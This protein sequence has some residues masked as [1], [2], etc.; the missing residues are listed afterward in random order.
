MFKTIRTILD[1]REAVADKKEIRFSE[2]DN[3]V[4]IGCY[5]FMDSRTFDTTEALEC[6]GIAFDRDGNVIS[7]PL[8]KFFNVGEKPWLSPESLLERDDIIGVYEKLDGSMIATAWIDEQLHWR[9]KKS[10]TS[11]VVTL[12]KQLLTEPEQSAIEDFATIVADHGCTAIFELTHPDA[13]I[14]VEQDRARLRLLHIRDNETG[15][16]VLTDSAN[17][18]WRLIED[19]GIPV[20]ERMGIDAKEAIASLET[21]TNCEGYVIQFANGDMCKLKCPWY[22]RLHRSI[23]FL[24]ERNIAELALCGELDDVKQSLVEAGVD[25]TAVL[26]VET[27]VKD[28]LV[29]ITEQVDAIYAEGNG[30]D[31]KS[32][33][34]KN[35]DHPLFSLAMSRYIGKELEVSDWYRKHRLREE[36]SLRVLANSAQA[37]AIEG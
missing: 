18:F 3:G 10:F 2:H 25:L 11:D 20:V 26:E 6:R 14:V 24:R 31:R 22:R 33:A 12:T 23:T 35:K 8:H 29:S 32:Y 15:E 21:M 37:E 17:P 9:S 19:M 34:I 28:A 27:R 30:L 1:V 16:Y 5:V 4:T 36:F 7:R 13:R